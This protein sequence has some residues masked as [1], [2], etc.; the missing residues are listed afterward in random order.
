VLY[1]SF[2]QGYKQW[3][4]KE[5][6]DFYDM[7]KLFPHCFD[8]ENRVEIF[9]HAVSLRSSSDGSTL[10]V[11]IRRNHLVDDGIKT[12]T[13]LLLNHNLHNRI[14]V[15]FV[16]QFGNLETGQDDGGLFKEFLYLLLKEV[17]EFFSYSF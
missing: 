9:Y 7:I 13:I 6:F 8:F 4:D 1:E 11:N 12:F 14:K 10:A 17:R 5:F 2:T 15:N 16:D 3:E